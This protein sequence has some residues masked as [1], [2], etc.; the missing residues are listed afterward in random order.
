M[1]YGDKAAGAA[2]VTGAV[3]TVAAMAHHPASAD[4]AM[5]GGL[6][7]GAML[8]LLALTAYG[9]AHFAIARGAARPPVLAGCI[10]YAT[11]AFANVGAATINGFVVPAL[12]E[13]GAGAVGRDIFVLAWEANQALAV[14]GVVATGAAFLLW[15]ADLLRRGGARERAIG[16]L[17]VAAG[18]L[19]VAM[20]AAGAIRMDVTG[21]LLVYAINAAWAALIGLH[22]LLAPPPSQSR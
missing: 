10:F 18:A 12:A 1:A 13:R 22:L 16:I 11:G 14:L 9:F 15:S 4:A 7:H 19:P 5:L 8:L 21:A 20:L 3:A 6:V 17:G 2:L